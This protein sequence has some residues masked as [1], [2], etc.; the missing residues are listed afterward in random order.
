MCNKDGLRRSRP[1]MTK[2]KEA[3]DESLSPFLQTPGYAPLQID[4]ASGG[5]I[6]NPS[7]IIAV[8]RAE[9]HKAKG[10][11]E[12]PPR[13]SHYVPT[14]EME[15][16]AHE[17]E[18][19]LRLASEVASAAKE[20][21]TSVFFTGSEEERQKWLGGELDAMRDQLVFSK[22]RRNEVW[23]KLGLRD[24]GPFPEILPTKVI[25]EKP[26]IAIT[27]ESTT[28]SAIDAAKQAS[29][30]W[31]TRVR[32]CACG[33]FEHGAVKGDSEHSSSNAGIEMVRLLLS[34]TALRKTWVLL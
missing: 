11:K 2:L 13:K 18:Q 28:S 14:W 31:I 7:T 26:D 27:T 34:E 10:L 5:D 24:S 9:A 20:R 16:Q 25:T 6:K 33:N 30:A 17:L 8:D 29:E 21:D 12:N 19:K 32:L 23:A 1:S 4:S 15:E 3:M 22:L